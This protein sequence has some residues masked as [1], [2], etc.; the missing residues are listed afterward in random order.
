MTADD[1]ELGAELRRLF[2]DARLDVRPR[3]GADRAVLAGVQRI[4][5]RRTMVATAGGALSAVVLVAGSLLV[6]DLRSDP[7]QAVVPALAE[8][9]PST[10][11][12]ESTVP[13][14]P[15][16]PSFTTAPV[17]QPPNTS[18]P[19]PE[20]RSS[21]PGT[22]P[23]TS[24]PPTVRISASQ[25]PVLGP[26]GYG[27]LRLGMS[28]QAAKATGMLAGAG[29]PPT[30]CTEYLLKEGASEIAAVYISPTDGILRFTA[31]GAHTP[32]EI[33]VGS[34]MAQLRAA[35]PN[36]S[37][38]SADYVAPTGSGG[39]YVFYVDDQGLVTSFELIG[40]AVTC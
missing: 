8:P 19:I 17:V 6:S 10:S 18:A 40:P 30:S 16:M 3:E 13:E 26:S 15:A 7:G 1:E 25:G 11:Q 32:Q 24:T 35:Y 36:L 33:T 31:R 12:P 2:D 14:T 21:G 38:N 37:K 34:S 28:F 20:S 9:A 22:P 27:A 39:S 5:R 23:A 29:T 4:R